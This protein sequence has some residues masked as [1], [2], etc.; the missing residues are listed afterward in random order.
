MT[1]NTKFGISFDRETRRIFFHLIASVS[2]MRL[3]IEYI[4]R[5]QIAVVYNF[6]DSESYFRVVGFILSLIMMYSIIPFMVR[7]IKNV[8]FSNILLFLLFLINFVP[9]TILMSYND[10][11]YLLPWYIYYFLLFCFGTK[12]SGA[13]AYNVQRIV[14]TKKT[15]FFFA[16][17]SATIVLFIWLYYGHGR[18]NFRLDDV[19]DRRMEAREYNMPMILNY[20]FASMKIVM[21][22]LIVWALDRKAT[23]MAFVFFFVQ[24]CIFFT[25]GSKST[26]FAVVVSI[27]GYYYFRRRAKNI[28]CFPWLI[29][30][31]GI[32]SILEYGLL[33][34]YNISGYFI[35]RYMFVPQRL[36]M[37]YYDFF[38]KHTPDYFRSSILKVFGIRSEYGSI[39]RMIGKYYSGDDTL[40]ANNGLF[41]DAFANLGYIGII[42]MPLLI[43]LMLK[44]L[45]RLSSGLRI[46]VLIGSVVPLLTAI[47]SA[48]YF[49]MFLSHG[50]LALMLIF[51][52]LPRGEMIDPLTENIID[53]I[54][55]S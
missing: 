27:I 54:D 7:C 47:M 10:L 14:M 39:A 13:K 11:P 24:L 21:P 25:D 38:S 49:T 36:N 31:I 48:S 32:A 5:T 50:V 53:L 45:N 23:R 4:Y 12:T 46:E 42:I 41:S 28:Q 34:S 8:C 16:G 2:I 20:I 6:V 52:F 37:Q 43:V 18:I 33:H 30:G 51:Y 19:Y 17:I 40:A 35:R 29:S 26:L 1:I 9:G 22:L 44:I 55:G 15:V 3:V